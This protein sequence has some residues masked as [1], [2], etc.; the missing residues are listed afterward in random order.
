MKSQ[1]GKSQRK[2]A[3]SPSQS[4]P[5]EVY[6]RIRPVDDPGDTVCVKP[7]GDS[8]VQ[9]IPPEIS[10]L[11]NGVT[12]E[13]Q[14]TFRQVFDETASQKAVFDQTALPLVE[15]LVA[16]KNGLLF[17]YG[18]T[19]SGKTYTMTGEP[20]DQGILP[21]CLDVLF[22]SIDNYQAKKYVFRP[23]RMNRFEVQTEADAMME[24]QRR[25]IMPNLTTPSKASL[26]RPESGE[27]ICDPTKVDTVEEDNNY[28][29]FVSYIEIYN[30]YVYDLLEE[31]PYNSITGYK[32]PQTKILRTD[33]GD[34]MY[35]HNC[36]EVEV[37]QSQDA[38]D[39]FYKGQRRR[40]VAHTAL[41]AESSRSHSVF[42]IRL[43][44]A[45]LDER[46]EEVVQDDVMCYDSE[47][48]CVSQLSL[49]DLAGSERSNRTK[50]S[51]DRLK[52][53]GNINQSLMVLRNCLEVLRENQKTGASKMV[54][55]RDSR[56]THLFK[57]FFDGD[58]KVRMIVCVNPKMTEYDETIHVMKFAEMTQEVLITKSQQSNKFDLGLTPGRRH[59]H[60][61]QLE[62]EIMN[63]PPLP[64]MLD[65]TFGPPFP[66][67]ELVSPTDD[68]TTRN[69][70][71]CLN[72]RIRRRQEM[73][74]DFERSC[75][76][77][78]SQLVEFEQDHKVTKS[79]LIEIEDKYSQKEKLFTK[80]ESKNKQLE[81]KVDELS[82]QLKDMERE[83]QLLGLQVQDKNWKIQAEKNNFDKLKADFRNRL[84][85]NNMAWEKNLEKARRQLEK[86]AENQ[87]DERDRKLE[88]LR[89]IVNE[90]DL[91][92]ATPSRARMRTAPQ[93][94]PKPRT[95]T[96]S[97]GIQT[98]ISETDI[99]SV[100]SST[101]ASSARAAAG[102]AGNTRVTSRSTNRIPAAKSIPNLSQVG[103]TPSSSKS[104]QPVVNPRYHRRS[105]SSGSAEQWLEHKPADIVETN[106][107]F[108]PQMTKKKSVTKLDVK[109]TKTAT[110]YVLTHQ[111]QDSSD[112]LVTKLIKG[113][114][115]PTLG[116]GA[117]VVFHD[118]ETLK[119]V[120]PGSRK[121]RSPTTPRYDPALQ[122]TDT[123]ERCSVALEGHKRSRTTNL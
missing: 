39:V 104:R 83:N 113:D 44:Q 93:P 42:N 98:A 77:F 2:Q 111:E 60:E 25:E 53:A 82:K 70:I 115:I 51:G 45:P 8:L 80:M 114:V 68:V 117:A 103:V 47:K 50:N 9:L 88:M 14:Y 79:R 38:I 46:G 86:E 20:Q 101:I 17:T 97:A 91:P 78:R 21:R 64:S 87:L 26:K 109:D 33:S 85:M 49:V 81:R 52:E 10:S 94:T 72:E 31:L 66:L 102:R 23:D 100:G 57:N 32:P 19:G 76:F 27:R 41:N 48:I 7:I 54:P 92:P 67:L 108:Q 55:Y 120:S 96:N 119:Q 34:N 118:V 58:G 13:F 75:A 122:W 105:K 63:P 24:R 71:Q 84:Q 3:A 56:L 121:R 28:A 123:E 89:D 106:T 22:N 43:V 40:K 61:L 35:V 90:N 65:F 59:L 69:I 29:V 112:E 30:N 11:R 36:T 1:R 18:V 95:Y 15:D 62:N 74:L 99:T 107:I 16:G 37:K 116:G 5:V 73:S 12:K 110:K 6:C 4:E